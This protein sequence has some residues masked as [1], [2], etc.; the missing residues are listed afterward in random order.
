MMI[1]IALCLLAYFF[2]SLSSAIILCRLSGL[3]DPRTQGSGNPGATNVLR[4]GGRGLAAQVLLGDMLKGLIP[5]LFAAWIDGTTSVLAA[6]A[7]C[8]FLGHLYPIFFNFK[9]GKGVAT[10]LGVILGLMWPVGLALIATWIT[11]AVTSRI[12]SLGALVAAIAAPF[13]TWYLSEHN[14]YIIL[15]AII[16]ILL[17]WRHR[18]NIQKLFNGTERK[19]GS[20]S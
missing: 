11:V 8:A 10:S 17:I 2:G 16:S 20:S 15:T 19:V 18:A 4:F 3:P 12:S 13:Y 6:V 1:P 9:G 5:V 7:L 14:Q